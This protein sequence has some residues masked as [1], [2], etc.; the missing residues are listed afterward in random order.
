MLKHA[1]FIP[2]P[3]DGG[4]KHPRNVSYTPTKVNNFHVSQEPYSVCLSL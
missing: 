3:E 1:V 4:G 2:Y